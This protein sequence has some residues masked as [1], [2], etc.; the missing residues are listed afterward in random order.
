MPTASSRSRAT[1][2]GPQRR[3][4][5]VLDAALAIAVETG[6]GAVTIG[7]VAERM[8]VTRPVVYACFPSRVE[9]V[10]ALLDRESAVLID[11]VLIAL[12]DSARHRDPEL[13]F[14]A[15]FRGLL[16][17]AAARPEAWHLILRGR[18]DPAIAARSQEAR[19]LVHARATAWIG[20]AM[21]AWWQTR[22]L[23]RKLPV[24]I[25]FFMSSCESAIRSLTA[26][27]GVW[28]PDDLGD[29]LGRAV[30]R[31]FRNA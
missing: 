5:Q 17:A 2:L 1:H 24:L 30:Y 18:P 26:P 22:D 23:E 27:D 16:H 21:A 12:H 28:S 4:P 11:S 14:V 19:D 31:A 3:R 8:G 9:L 29:F 7:A 10:D 25:D 13:V 6:L 15:G 20:P